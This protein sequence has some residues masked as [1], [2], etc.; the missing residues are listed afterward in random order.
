MGS[1]GG[2]GEEESG[3]AAG[4]GGSN[5]L[6]VLYTNAQSVV[7]KMAELRAVVSIK[8]P[9]VIALTETW[10]NP[11]ISNEYLSLDGYELMERKDREDTDRGRGGGILVYVAKGICAWKVEVPR[12]FEQRALVKLRRKSGELGIYIIYRSPNSTSNND[13]SLCDLVKEIRDNDIL[14]GD[15]NFPGIHWET[16]RADAKGRAFY[17]EMEENFL[18]QYTAC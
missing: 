3:G 6:K 12:S 5:E 7:N 2:K 9:D 17:E 15:F 11:D 16:G 1:G 14:I 8:Q 4:G 18:I 13:A 10:T